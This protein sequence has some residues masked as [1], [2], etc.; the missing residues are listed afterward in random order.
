VLAGL[1]RDALRCNGRI[2]Q[3]ELAFVVEGV[4]H[5]WTVA[6]DWYDHLAERA[7][8]LP[9]REFHENWDLVFPETGA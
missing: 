4:L 9:D 6:A 7:S 3:L 1:R 5:T 2:R 8:A